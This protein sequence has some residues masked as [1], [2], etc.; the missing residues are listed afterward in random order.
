MRVRWTPKATSDVAR[1]RDFL[2]AVDPGASR[3]TFLAIKAGISRLEEFP[4]LGE[5]VGGSE[6]RELR[7][8]VIGNYELHYEVAADTILILRLWHVRQDRTPPD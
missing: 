6:A 5:R 7:R 2:R 3:R 8:L 4:R 1:L